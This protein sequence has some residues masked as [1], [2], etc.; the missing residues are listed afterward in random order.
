MPLPQSL[1]RTVWPSPRVAALIRERFADGYGVD[2]MLVQDGIPERFSRR[3]LREINAA[4][5]GAA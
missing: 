4:K 3:I 2:D 5:R 1:A